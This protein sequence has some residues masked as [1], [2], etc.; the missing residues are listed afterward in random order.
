MNTLLAITIGLLFQSPVQEEQKQTPISIQ[1]ISSPIT[2]D[3]IPDEPAWQ[4]IEPF[5]MTVYQPVYG[6]DM[7]NETIIKVAYDDEYLYVAGELYDS[8]PEHIVANTLYR[9]RYSGDETF[10]IILDSFNDNEN[11]K[12]FFVT[13]TG[14]RVDQQISNDSEGSNSFNRDWNTYWDAAAQITDEGWFAEMRI[15]FSSL[16]FTEVNEEVIMGLI[17]YRWDARRAERHIFPDIAPE[18]SRGFTKPTQAQKVKFTGIEYRKPVYV[19]PYLLGGFDQ[20]NLLNENGNAFETETDYVTEAGLDI[21]Y[22]IS[23]N[24]NLDITLNTDFAQV[25]ADEAQV[26]LSRTPLFF[27]EKRQ[28][29]QERSDIF[30]FNLGGNNA[31]FYSRRI[32]LEQGQ[33]VRI[34]GG[35]RLAGR[36]GGWDIGILNLQTDRVNSHTLPSENFGVYRAKRNVINQNS[37]AGGMITNRIGG[38]GS[39]NVGAGFDLLLNYKG[40][41]FLDVKTATTFDDR[42]PSN[43]LEQSLLRFNLL[44]RTSSGFYYDFSA[45]RSGEH[46]LPEVGFNPRYNYSQFELELAYGHFSSPESPVRIINPSLKS[47]LILRNEDRSVESFQI[48]QPWEIEL[49]NDTELSFIATVWY[50]DL[51]FPLNFGESS[52]VDA[53][54]YTFWGFEAEYEMPSS[55]QV[56]TS[57]AGRAGTFYDGDQYSLTFSPA[58]NPS[59]HF[60]ISADAELNFLQFPNRNQSEYLHLFRVRSIMA[61]NTHLSLQVL[62][63]YSH[64]SKQFGTNARFRYNFSEGHDFWIVYSELSNRD[65]NR[66]T[67]T[68]PRFENRTMLVKYTYTFY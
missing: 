65:L 4:Q 23:G 43:A 42:T 52:F 2:L 39:Y 48:E 1:R 30:D 46:Y 20:I 31:L 36:T 49:K 54:S 56:R 22:P 38:D 62:S 57:I 21:K 61:L 53:G 63:Q 26:N 47:L 50:E 55:K 9:D 13:P 33:Q 68:L 3:G 12:W 19:T 37:H 35:A 7:S 6:G 41:H 28:F 11:A 66:I 16:G 51:L 29:F 58:W 17:T 15:P 27:P 18:W 5:P 67:P 64:R 59:K 24:M 45:L 60:E 40:N 32:G 44:K 14:V 25:E 10:A 8:E 34:L